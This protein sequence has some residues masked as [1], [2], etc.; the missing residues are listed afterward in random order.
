M[1]SQKEMNMSETT[2]KSTDIIGEFYEWMS[3]VGLKAFVALRRSYLEPGDLYLEAFT[4]PFHEKGKGAGRRIL[5]KLIEIAETN[6]FPLTLE[7]SEESEDS[8]WLQAWYMRHG[9]VYSDRG[10]GDYGPYMIRNPLNMQNLVRVI[11]SDTG[12]FV[13]WFEGPFSSMAMLVDMKP[14]REAPA[15]PAAPT[16]DRFNDSSVEAERYFEMFVLTDQ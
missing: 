4:V 10:H 16:H 5:A 1:N 12:K 11:N 3:N 8:E 13:Q 15:R 6:A 14:T 2:L 7:A 9:F